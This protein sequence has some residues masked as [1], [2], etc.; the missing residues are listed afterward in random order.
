M[1]HPILRRMQT[2]ADI[3]LGCEWY[4]FETTYISR[5]LL[6]C[7][8]VSTYCFPLHLQLSFSVSYLLVDS[9]KIVIIFTWVRCVLLTL[10][11]KSFRYTRFVVNNGYFIGTLAFCVFHRRIKES[12][13]FLS[14]YLSNL[15]IHNILKLLLYLV[16]VCV[17]CICCSFPNEVNNITRCIWLLLLEHLLRKLCHSAT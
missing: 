3:W 5:V 11:A 13:L 4:F 17:F 14:I 9:G 15:I 1:S 7:I 16:C 8:S 6:F 10:I 2:F 12:I